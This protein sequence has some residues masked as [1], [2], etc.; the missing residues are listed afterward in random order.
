MPAR[1]IEEELDRLNA[2]RSLPPSDTTI[3]ALRK[4]LRDRVNLVAAKA[5]TITAGLG[6]KE[7]LPDLE[8][9]FERFFQNPIQTDP[10]CWAKNAISKALKDLD[11]ADSALFLRGLQ[12]VQMEPVYG[13]HADSAAVLRGTCALA[14]VQ[15]R[16][17][18]RQEIMQHL[19]DALTE[20]AATVRADAARALESMGGQDAP[21]LLRLKVRAGDKEPAVTGQALD[22]LL[23]LEGERAVPF[24]AAFLDSRD[25]D[26]QE[27]AAL[28]L[29]VSRLPGAID[30]LTDA[31]SKYRNTRSA[32][33]L[34]RAISAS[35]QESGFEFLLRL[36]RNG[37]ETEARDAVRALELHRESPEI[38]KRVQDALESRIQ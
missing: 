18:P 22:S 37:S 8:K 38:A 9:A 32:E 30:V 16:D 20:S 12:H 19:I 4:A 2:V 29:G 10:Q 36:I 28:S 27:Q 13:G 24:V 6:L 25:E 23:T 17:I 21:L 1:K 26:M 7:L 5:A 11:Y 3:L 31:Y 35:R 14:L 34:L 33:P 15:C